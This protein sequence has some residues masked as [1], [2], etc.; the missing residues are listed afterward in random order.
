VGTSRAFQLGEHVSI[1]PSFNDAIKFA[2]LLQ[3]INIL[4]NKKRRK[5]PVKRMWEAVALTVA[6]AAGTLGRFYRNKVPK[7]CRNCH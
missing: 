5:R 2:T 3:P 1:V 6:A 7:G 4:P